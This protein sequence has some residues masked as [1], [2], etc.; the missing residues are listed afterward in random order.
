[1]LGI[2]QELV[3]GCPYLM[4][5]AG[6]ADG[7]EERLHAVWLALLFKHALH[8]SVDLGRLRLGPFSLHRQ[9]SG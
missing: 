8:H 2:M 5:G 3:P 1:M 7:K 4:T 9:P 6:Q